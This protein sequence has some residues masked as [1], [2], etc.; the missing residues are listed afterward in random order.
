M[1][2]QEARDNAILLV[3]GGSYAYGTNTETSDEDERGIVIAPIECYLGLSRF[4]QAEDKIND[5]VI[6]NIVKFFDLALKANPNIWDLLWSEKVIQMQDPHGERLRRSR[7]IFLST[8]ARWTFS[9]YAFAQLKRIKT[10][11]GYLLGNHPKAQPNPEDY[12]IDVRW[13]MGKDEIG[14]ID[15]LADSLIDE[16]EE[17]LYQGAY[18]VGD[19]GRITL[20]KER[21]REII[22][23]V[24]T[25]EK[26]EESAAVINLS[27]EI[28]EMYSK[29]KRYHQALNEWNKY[30]NWKKTRNRKC[31]DLEKKFGYDTKHGMQLVRLLRM[32]HEILEQGIVQVKRPDAKE[33]LEIRNGSWS[34][35]QIEAFAEE[36]EKV[37]DE[38]YKNSPLPKKPDFAEAEK[39][40]VEIIADYHKLRR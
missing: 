11:R 9:G 28:M 10:H 21:A 40:L 37:F 19:D 25:E 36:E 3:L 17:Q 6:Y 13:K 32:G 12:G 14:A 33:L 27:D 7:D 2:Y 24:L 23:R 29:V 22:I 4:D 31:A 18:A 16:F 35:E 20:N 8:K 5:G 38:L 30:K 34:Y 1:R 26:R 15:A 39:L